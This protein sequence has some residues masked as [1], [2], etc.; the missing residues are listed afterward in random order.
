MLPHRARVGL[1]AMAI[2]GYSAFPKAPAFLEPPYQISYP[3][4]SLGES[5]PS[6]ERQSGPVCAC[7]YVCLNL[8]V[9]RFN[10]HKNI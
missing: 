4:H 10:Y 1:G 8:H 2:K 3:G 9:K 6:I 5:Y 7:V